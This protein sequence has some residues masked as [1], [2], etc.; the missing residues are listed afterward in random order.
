MPLAYAWFGAIH[1]CGCFLR[2]QE[3]QD[4]NGVVLKQK[5]TISWKMSWLVRQWRQEKYPTL[6]KWY[7]LL[8]LQAYVEHLPTSF[9]FEANFLDDD[10]VICTIKYDLQTGSLERCPSHPRKWILQELFFLMQ[11]FPNKM[12]K[13]YSMSFYLR[14]CTVLRTNYGKKT[15]II[16]YANK[17]LR[18]T[19]SQALN[20][21][22][23]HGIEVCNWS[24]FSQ[25]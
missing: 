9:Q 22:L 7:Y 6:M 23:K 10:Q 8:K 17:F 3:V 11:T 1:I 12:D 25:F 5:P 2:D 15:T 24:L 20:V 19:F 13:R 18:L 4:R 14:F 21:C 16:Q